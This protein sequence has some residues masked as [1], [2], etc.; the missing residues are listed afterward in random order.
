[1]NKNIKVTVSRKTANCK[2]QLQT[3]SS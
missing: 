2:E 1:V 3:L